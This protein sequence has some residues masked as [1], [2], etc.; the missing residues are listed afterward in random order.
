VEEVVCN[1]CGSVN[2]HKLLTVPV[3]RFGPTG[4][5]NLVECR[6]CGLCYLN[7]RPSPEEMKDYYPTAYREYRASLN[8]APRRRYQKEKLRKL[9][10]HSQGGKLLDVG[11]A[12]G[13]FLHLARQANWEV[14]G[15]EMAEE[16][17]AQA[18]ENYKLDVFS[19][20][21]RDANLPGRR[22]DAVTFWHVLEH[23]HDP[24]GDL[25]EA[26]RVLKPNGLLV[27][28]VPN[29]ASWQAR[30]FGACWRALDTPRHLYHFSSDSLKAMLA[31][32]G[33]ARVAISYWSAGHNMGAW[34]EGSMNLVF[35]LLPKS[36]D[37]LR[38]PRA[39]GEGPARYLRYALFLPLHWSTFIVEQVA[40]L[41]GQSGDMT[42]FARKLENTETQ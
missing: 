26:Y 39:F 35:R 27:V 3:Q 36:A 16:S 24:L 7:P 22:F 12:D 9:G 21:L 11:C 10:A 5:F 37:E 34:N 41:S 29:I 15:V 25:R 2:W 40:V 30:L 4:D 8:E 33:L 17:A 31:R 19:G 28:D 1:L 13:L 18:R 38:S 32:A 6:D 14:Q 42:V 23:L 20:G